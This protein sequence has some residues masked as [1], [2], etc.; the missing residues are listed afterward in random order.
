[1]RFRFLLR[2]FA[3]LLI[4]FVVQKVVFMLYNMGMADGAPFLSCLAALWHGLRLD[5]ATACYLVIIPTVVLIVSFFFQRFPLR[6]VLVPYYVLIAT[7]FMLAFAVDLVLYSYWGSKPDANDL[8]YAAKPRE[9]L[10]GL[11]IWFTIIGFAI[12][13]LLVWG[14]VML[15]RWRSPPSLCRMMSRA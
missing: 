7:V 2:F 13:A 14:C 5:V 1:M 11:P 9:A 12:L 4:L 6:R 10:A 3:V 15:M 8:I